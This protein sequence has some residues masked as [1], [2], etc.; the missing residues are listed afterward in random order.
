M[1]C[2]DKMMLRMLWTRMR[3]DDYVGGRG[4]DVIATV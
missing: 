1:L 3:C 2:R 4:M